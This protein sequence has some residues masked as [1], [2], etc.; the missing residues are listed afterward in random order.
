MTRHTKHIDMRVGGYQ[1]NESEFRFVPGL[2]A[3]G[4]YRRLHDWHTVTG[5]TCE[6]ILAVVNEWQERG[7]GVIEATDNGWTFSRR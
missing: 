6:R 7:L 1:R 5:A 4:W 3:P 2:D